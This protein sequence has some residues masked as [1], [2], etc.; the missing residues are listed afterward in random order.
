MDYDED[1]DTVTLDL[2]HRFTQAHVA[3]GYIAPSINPDAVEVK[4]RKVQNND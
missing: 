3:C 2:V 4:Q 1:M